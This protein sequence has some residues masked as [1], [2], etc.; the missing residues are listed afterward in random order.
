[1]LYRNRFLMLLALAGLLAFLSLS[2]QFF[3]LIP[4]STTKNGGSSKSRKRVMPDPVTEPPTVDPVYEALLYCNIPSVAEHSMEGHAPHHYKL[5]SVHVFIRHGDRYPLYAIP[6]TKRPEIDCTLVAS[7]K[8]YHPK[9]EAFVS[10]MS[11][12]SGA[13]FESPLNSLPLYPNHLLCEMGELTQTGVVQHLQNGQLLRDIYLRK[14]KLLPN[15]WSSEQLYLETTGKSR[16]LQ[17]G[18][19][20]LYGFLPDFDW[21]KIYFKHQ[22]S[23]LFCSGSCYCPLRNHYLEKEQRR[24]YLLRLKNRDLERTYGEMAK[25][26]DI[27]TKQLRAANPIDS[28]LCHFCHNVSF[29]CSRSGCLG[30]EHFKVIKTHQIEDERERHEKPLYFGYSLLGAH[31]ILNQTVNR[32]QRA[33]EGWTDE[34]FTLYS[35]HDVTLSPVLSALGL[36]EARFPRFA[37]RLVFEL[38]QDRQKPSEH[39]VRIL[40]NGADVTFHTSFCHDFHKRSPKPMCPLENLVR[41]VKRDMFVALDGSSTN[42]YDACHGEGA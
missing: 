17:S 32:M 14:H 15:N 19:A 27:P 7:R 41:F 21:K 28:M 3:H 30:M 16:T 38:W 36:L 11:K 39:S 9:L 5:V 1:M 18:L 34:L 23:A 40:Y 26:V 37:A 20:L 13:S 24:Q 12:G 8:P 29:P 10:H 35:A 22:P 6:K 42:Y 31:P 4:V 33:A 2:L 25:I